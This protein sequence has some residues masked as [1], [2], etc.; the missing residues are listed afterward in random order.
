[1]N[2]FSNKLTLTAIVVFATSPIIWMITGHLFGDGYAFFGFMLLPL[3]VPAALCMYLLFW[4][5]HRD[6]KSSLVETLKIPLYRLM[7][8]VLFVTYVLLCTKI[9]TVYSVPF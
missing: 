1:M 6:N 3:T 8:L 2:T 4:V 9:V 7:Q 5:R